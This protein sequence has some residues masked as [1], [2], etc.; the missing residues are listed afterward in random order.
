M[1]WFPVFF[2][3]LC[4]PPI[5]FF[6]PEHAKYVLFFGVYRKR[7]YDALQE[8]LE[9]RDPWAGGRYLISLVWDAHGYIWHGELK[10]ILMPRGLSVFCLHY[11]YLTKIILLQ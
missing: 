1:V 8:S 2:L 9:Q 4:S 10:F 6:I 11:L 5:L 3:I 7:V